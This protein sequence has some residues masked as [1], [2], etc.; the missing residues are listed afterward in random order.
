MPALLTIVL[1]LLVI[2]MQTL[3]PKID[4]AGW[5]AGC[6]D[7]TR[8]GRHVVEHWLPAE[9]GTLMGVSRTVA[10]GKTAEWEFLIIR[11]GA[12]GL[13]YVARPSGQ[14]EAVF[15]STRVSGAE[16]VFENPTH[17]FPTRI[18]YA[19]HGDAPH[20]LEA[21]RLRFW[22]AGSWFAMGSPPRSWA[23]GSAA[24]SP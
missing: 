17:D 22:P 15:T 21:A 19:R 3:P 18:I 20:S 23:A 14:A 24:R 11:A 4:D 12:K 6:W 8:N 1:A 9:G 5:I 13:E 10:N 2:T 16:I 7:Y